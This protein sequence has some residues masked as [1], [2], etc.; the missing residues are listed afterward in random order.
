VRCINIKNYHNIPAILKQQ[1]QWVVW[2]IVGEPPKAPFNP[3]SLLK[4]RAVPAKSGV[5]DT[6][7]SFEHAAQCVAKG[8]AKGI[9]YEFDGSGVYGVDLD[10]VISDGGLVT[11]EA[12]AT[13]EELASYTEVS[14]SGR[15]LH[16]FVAADNINITRH[17]RQGGFVEIYSD[18]RYFTVTG[19]IYGDFDCIADRPAELQRIHDHFLIDNGELKMD[20]ERK[21]DV[22][23]QYQLSTINSQ[24]ER[25]LEKDPVL[26]ACWNGENRNGDESA[27]DQALMNKLAYWCSADTQAMIAAFMSSPYFAQKDE[28]HRRKCQRAD[29]L[30]N[31]AKAACFPLRSTAREDAERFRRQKNYEKER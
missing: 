25:G 17:R 29:Y 11:P 8:L 30:P 28:A 20:N 12:R 3:E 1:R 7:G 10:H 6:W 21:P 16:I 2:G 26:R 9:G 14:P 23:N 24:L 19:N 13:V 27:S 15:G 22:L 31:T 5:P 18:A 4:L